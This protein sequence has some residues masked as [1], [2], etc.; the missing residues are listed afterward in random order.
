[1]K[2]VGARPYHY[3]YLLSFRKVKRGS[4]FVC[5]KGQYTD[6]HDD[7]MDAVKAGAFAVVV[8][9]SCMVNVR[10][11]CFVANMEK[12]A[13]MNSCAIT[14]MAVI[15]VKDTRQALAIPLHFTI[16]TKKLKIIGITGTKGK[17]TTAFLTAGILKEAG[18]KTV[19]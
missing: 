3:G 6:G 5:I 10:W 4:L 9:E 11:E 14:V 18:Y 16:I 15:G 2:E 17:T 8:D 12:C 7:I 13:C 1:M 19:T